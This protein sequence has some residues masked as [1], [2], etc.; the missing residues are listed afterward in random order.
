MTWAAIASVQCRW[1]AGLLRRLVVWSWGYGSAGFIGKPGETIRAIVAVSDERGRW[2]KVKFDKLR[3]SIG[4]C[5]E[6]H[7]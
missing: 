2:H 5:V 4:P 7:G 1:R 6:L 3:S